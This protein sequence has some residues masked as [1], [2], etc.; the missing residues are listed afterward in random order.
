MKRVLFYIYHEKNSRAIYVDLR[1]QE[2]AVIEKRGG[3]KK[4]L[5]LPEGKDVTEEYEYVYVPREMS[6]KEISRRSE[7]TGYCPMCG[8]YTS[9]YLSRREMKKYDRYVNSRFCGTGKGHQT[10]LIQDLFPNRLDK[11]KELMKTGYCYRCQSL[12]FESNNFLLT[13]EPEFPI[14]PEHL[15]AYNCASHDGHRWLSSW[16]PQKEI[17]DNLNLIVE[18]DEFRDYLFEELLGKGISDIP[19]VGAYYG[20]EPSKDQE[21]HIYGEGDYCGY[22]VRLI[23]RKKDYKVYIYVYELVR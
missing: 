11:E 3:R 7:V 23:N 15:I 18:M 10:P 9:I 5:A 14:E 1:D 6:K 20:A 4:I 8:K 13:A 19:K 22:D 12:L 2:Y 21:Y 16:F 17:G